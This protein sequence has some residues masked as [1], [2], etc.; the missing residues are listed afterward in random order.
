MLQEMLVIMNLTLNE[1]ET[2]ASK[3]KFY[4]MNVNIGSNKTHVLPLTTD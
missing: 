1:K 2:K 3:N 4:Q